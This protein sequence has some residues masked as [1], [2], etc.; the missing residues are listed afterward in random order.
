MSRRAPIAS[1]L[2]AV[3][4][5]LAAGPLP[6][7]GAAPGPSASVGSAA[8][9]TPTSYLYY[10]GARAI[11]RVAVSGGKP[12]VV[13]DVNSDSITGITVTD[14]RVIWVEQD[15]MGGS[16]SYVTLGGPTTPKVLV[17]NVAFGTGLVSAG[18]RVYW[19][20]QDA[21]G[22]VQ[23]SGAQLDRSFIKL[24]QENGG[25]IADGLATNGSYLYFSRCQDDAIGRVEADGKGTDLSF[26][27]VPHPDCPQGLAVGGNYLYMAELSGPSGY[28]GR[29]TLAGTGAEPHW[30]ATRVSSGPF[31]LAADDADVYWDWGGVAGSPTYV[32]R[33]SV[34]GTGLNTKLFTGQ[35]AFFLTSRGA[36]T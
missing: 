13:A 34:E 9:A 36:N 27:T 18:G 29:V 8:A 1:V 15:G 11:D 22:R 4:G 3:T 12:Q 25:G 21:I 14:N 32:A 10:R 28:V 5:G 7:A 31:S 24:P 35:G 19:A 33:A 20:G 6:S 16:V 2:L 23:P 26:V 17:S 30:L